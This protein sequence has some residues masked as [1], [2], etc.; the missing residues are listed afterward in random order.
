MVECQFNKQVKRV[1]SYNITEFTCLGNYF[2][3]HGIVHE[4]SCAGTPQQ[5]GHVEC[6]HR[7]IL[8]VACALRFQANLPIEF[9]GNAF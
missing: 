8:N 6:K 9:G 4:T 2:C 3:E 5:N 7:H 1:R